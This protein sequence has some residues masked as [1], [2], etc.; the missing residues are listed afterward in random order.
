MVGF[1]YGSIYN[2]TAAGTDY[3][4]VYKASTPFSTLKLRVV[5][6]WDS[7]ATCSNMGTGSASCSADSMD[8]DLDLRVR[9]ESDNHTWY[10]DTSGASYEYIQIDATAGETYDIIINVYSWTATYTYFGLSWEIAA[11]P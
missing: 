7:T 4:E 1:D 9:R 2:S 11:F 10:S 3:S 6:S 8:A 5:L